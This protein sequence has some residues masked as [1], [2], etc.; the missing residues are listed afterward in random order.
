MRQG[1]GTNYGIVTVA[2]S[3]DTLSITGRNSAGDWYQVGL[4]DG[5]QGWVSGSLVAVSG[6]AASIPVVATPAASAAVTQSQGSVIVFQ[7]SSGG[8]IY[9]VNPDGSNLR[10]LTTGMDPAIS[11]DGQWVAFTRWDGVQSGIT[12]SLWV[13]NVDGSRERQVMSGAHQPK[14]PTWSA[15]GQK[16]IISMQNG[17]TVDDTW[18]C[19][20][21][22]KPVESPGP[23][24]G[25]RC[26]PQRANPY[27][28][29]RVGECVQR[30]L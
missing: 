1:P 7:V 15:D 9:A 12:G 30:R 29:L 23:I 8:Q 27:W 25:Q 28:G 18:M 6:D 3:A 16:I 21:D 17:G 11:P 5:R 10:Y 14:S 26:M 24:E 19:M 20:I 22:G 13:I 2:H 4:D